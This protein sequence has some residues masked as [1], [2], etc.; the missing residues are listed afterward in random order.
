MLSE[1]FGRKNAVGLSERIVWTT[2]EPLQLGYRI[3][4]ASKGFGGCHEFIVIFSYLDQ[5]PSSSLFF[6]MKF[7]IALL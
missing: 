6:F 5:D 3:D 1:I 4:M 2:P 7:M